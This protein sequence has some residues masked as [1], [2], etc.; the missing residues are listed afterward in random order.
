MKYLLLLT[1][2]VLLTSLCTVPNFPLDFSST[3]ST[4][5]AGVSINIDSG[6]PDILLNVEAPVSE[7][8]SGREVQVYFDLTNKQ[9]YNL[10]NVALEVYDYSETCF[11]QG[12]FTN[13][14]GTIKANQSK[15]WVWK[16]Q[17]ND[18]IQLETMC[19][20]RFRTS[21]DAGYSYFQDI[22]VLP[23]SEYLQ[24]ESQGTLQ[25]IPISSSYSSSPLNIQVTFSEDQPFLEKQDYYM[26]I[27]YYN[28]GQGIFESI[29]ASISPPANINLDCSPVYDSSFKLDTVNHPIKFL[30]GRATPTTCIFT[31][32]AVSAMDIKS[33]GLTATYKYVLDNSIS[34]TVKP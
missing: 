21:Y 19:P 34:I 15:I 3:N 31:T 27:N 17:T 6:S 30:R 29:D 13:N 2:L 8:R 11:K 9:A 26:Y 5:Q 16:F 23:Q 10:N 32:N 7:V 20:I 12:S 4:Q 14:I 28:T 24:R 25:N 33:I 18:N 22:A 1:L